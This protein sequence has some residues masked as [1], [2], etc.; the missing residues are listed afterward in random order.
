[1]LIPIFE[2]VSHAMRSIRKSSLKHSLAKG[3]KNLAANM[4]GGI[5]GG[6]SAEAN[7]LSSELRSNYF[8]P[9]TVKAPE[10]VEFMIDQETFENENDLT[11]FFELMELASGRSWIGSCCYLDEDGIIQILTRKNSMEIVRSRAS[12]KNRQTYFN[13]DVT[14]PHF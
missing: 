11:R 1:M 13:C 6:A 9:V 2:I 12:T 14:C 4:A 5:V 8:F 10:R 3:S 7:I